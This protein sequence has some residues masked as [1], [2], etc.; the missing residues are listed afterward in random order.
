[1]TDPNATKYYKTGKPHR[2]IT[3]HGLKSFYGCER[4]KKCANYLYTTLPHLYKKPT[5]NV[6]YDYEWAE[7]V[8]RLV[9]QYGSKYRKLKY[10]KHPVIIFFND[11]YI[12]DHRAIIHYVIMQ[13]KVLPDLPYPNLFPD[14]T[15]LL[16]KNRHKDYVYFDVRV[17][18]LDDYVVGKM[19]FELHTDLVPKTCNYFKNLCVPTRDRGYG[20]NEQMWKFSYLGST[21]HRICGTSFIQGGKIEGYSLRVKDENY[22]VKHCRRGVISMCNEGNNNSTT[23]FCICLKENQWLDDRV[24]AFGQLIFGEP[25]LT[26]IQEVPEYYHTPLKDIIIVGCGVIPGYEEREDYRFRSGIEKQMEWINTHV[27]KLRMKRIKGIEAFEQKVKSFLKMRETEKSVECIYRE[28][29]NVTAVQD[30]SGSLEGQDKQTEVP[31]A[32]LEKKFKL[33]GKEE[34]YLKLPKTSDFTLE[35][36][37]RKK[38]KSN[39]LGLINLMSKFIDSIVENIDFANSSDQ[40]DPLNYIPKKVIRDEVDLREVPSDELLESRFKAGL[41]SMPKSI[42]RLLVETFEN[43]TP[44]QLKLIGYESREILKS[45][46]VPD[47]TQSVIGSE[48]IISGLLMCVVSVADLISE[49]GT[50]GDLEAVVAEI[51]QDTVQVLKQVGPE[52]MRNMVGP[53]E[54]FTDPHPDDISTIS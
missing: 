24:V 46:G 17:G 50:P 37:M 22:L 34:H 29:E 49:P 19:V 18:G 52:M 48:D 30:M 51:R 15:D 45:A 53:A 39:D 44:S 42:R 7:V 35:E 38:R 32:L 43:L 2:N 6:Y 10:L 25:I 33:G 14:F 8:E 5:V 40:I 12:G 1:M 21:I 41:Y 16:P 3:I 28:D 20:E 27:E 31:S 36:L 9:L 47:S 13:H 26:A 23:E 4:A 11:K 54:L